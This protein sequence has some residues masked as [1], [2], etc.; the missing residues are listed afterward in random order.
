MPARQLIAP[1][2]ARRPRRR[3][4]LRKPARRRPWG[5]IGETCAQLGTGALALAVATIALVNLVPHYR[6]QQERLQA[7]RGEVERTE[8][9]VERLRARLQRNF[10]PQQATAVMQEQTARVDPQLWPIVFLE[11]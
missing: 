6:A 4:P 3:P 11:D 2:P 9:R 10:D 7:V 5:Q 8:R 1:Q